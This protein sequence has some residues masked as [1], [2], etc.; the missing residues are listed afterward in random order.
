MPTTIVDAMHCFGSMRRVGSARAGGHETEVVGH[1]DIRSRKR[2][3]ED[4]EFNWQIPLANQLSCD[5]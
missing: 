2:V 4:G 3:G 1:L 5:V